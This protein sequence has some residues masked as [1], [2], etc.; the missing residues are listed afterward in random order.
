MALVFVH[1]VSHT[2]LAAAS[3]VSVMAPPTR[4]ARHGFDLA[5]AHSVREI[6]SPTLQARERVNSVPAVTPGWAAPLTAT[7]GCAAHFGIS[8]LIA[9]SPCQIRKGP[10][11]GIERGGLTAK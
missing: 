7:V 6:L 8:S 9:N 10:D 3:S 5:V 4:N 1:I 2:L 11:C